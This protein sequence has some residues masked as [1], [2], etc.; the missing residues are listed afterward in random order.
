LSNLDRI[1]F[2]GGEIDGVWF[3]ARYSYTTS[4][5]WL[6]YFESVFPEKS[7]KMRAYSSAMEWSENMH[8]DA[9][10]PVVLNWANKKL[11]AS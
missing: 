1:L 10:F 6:S 7:K 3:H 9:W 11:E 2:E 4:Q 5:A 8:H